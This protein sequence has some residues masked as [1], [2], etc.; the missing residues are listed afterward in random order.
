MI[1]DAV[2][3]IGI[4]FERRLSMSWLP[5]ASAASKRNTP[6]P[7]R[8]ARPVLEGLEDRCLLAYALTD[9]GTLGGI[10]SYAYGINDAG[11]VV[12]SSM[13]TGFRYSHAYTYS[14]GAMTDL[15][16]LKNLGLFS[17]AEDINSSGHIVGS[18]NYTTG[19]S[20][21]Y[22]AFVYKNNTMTDIGSLGGPISF[23]TGINSGGFVSGYGNYSGGSIEK[24]HAFKWDPNTNQK[25]DLG[26]LGGDDSRAYDIN[27]AG[28]VVGVSTTGSQSH[29]FYH[30]GTS[31]IDI[32]VLPGFEVGSE[33]RAVN[34]VGL[35]VGGSYGFFGVHNTVLWHGFIYDPVS[36]QM[37]DLGNLGQGGNWSFAYDINDLG[38]VVGSANTTF[39]DS[40]RH[41]WVWQSGVM[42]DLNTEIPQGTGW[43]LTEAYGINN[44]GQIVGYG[45]KDGKIRGFMLT[46]TASAAAEGSGRAKL[47][48]ATAKAL[49]AQAVL[50]RSLSATRVETSQRVGASTPLIA[51]VSPAKVATTEYSTTVVTTT[52]RLNTSDNGSALTTVQL[53]VS[54]VLNSPM[55]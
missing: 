15:G 51:E 42:K 41:A 22:H 34:N 25:T 3:G 30:N 20:S 10:A 44:N 43:V 53:D 38:Q 46:P 52:A 28:T 18:S 40:P 27:D 45:F 8:K 1:L 31:M 50:E 54:A 24:F 29:A 9:L 2:K 16:V 7:E 49:R 17:K 26:T 33:A 11:T 23:G 32:G 21:L 48:P 36:N 4:S 39:G 13:V 6:R 37:T 5:F 35:A 14:G 47:D 19:S 55:A 12:G